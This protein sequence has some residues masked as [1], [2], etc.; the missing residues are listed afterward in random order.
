MM[1]SITTTHRPATDLGYL[2]HKN[3]DNIHEIPLSFGTARVFYPEASEKRCTAVLLAQIDPIDLVRA[4]KGPRGMAGQLTQYVNDR[5]YVASSFLSGAVTRAYGA[6]LNG[7]SKERPELAQTAIP[8]EVELP[9]VP[10][11]GGEAL[12]RRL[13]EPLDYRVDCTPLTFTH[14]ELEMGDGIYV[15]L[16]LETTKPLVDVLRHLYVLVPVLDREKHYWVGPDEL[17]KLMDKGKSWLGDHPER[18]LILER[19]LK[20]MRGLVARA[21]LLLGGD[22]VAEDAQQTEQEAA[23]EKPLSLNR[24]RLE[25]VTAIL[26][27]RQPQS[28]ADL[29]C[30]E[31][32]LT[33]MLLQKTSIPKIIA[34]DVEHKNLEAAAKRMHLDTAP[35]KMRERVQLLCGSLLYRDRRLRGIE[36]AALI[37]VIEH[38][39][40]Q[41]LIHL[42]RAVLGYMAP[43]LLL[44]S[45]PNREYNRH[46]GLAEGK[47]RHGDHR[48]EWD[49]AQFREWCERVCATHGYRHQILPI[50][51]EHPETGAPTQLAILEKE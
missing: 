1:L 15:H 17:E 4:Y 11:R 37:E 36:A 38:L 28:I 33:A 48:F 47:L 46:F 50:G 18:D 9:V 44:V 7:R 8:L 10:A 22:S 31:G 19:Y 35:P 20:G 32:R 24:Q 39:E 5:P 14:P 3:P 43:S 34:L 45:T 23:L 6:A 49:R 26:K 25:T 12:V 40:P 42:E 41:R 2:L 30:G 29:G 27:Q 13:F 16:R 21:R 51:E